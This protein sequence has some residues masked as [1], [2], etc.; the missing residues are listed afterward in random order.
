MS[1]KEVSEAEIQRIEREMSK[2]GMSSHA[3]T[4]KDALVV[5]LWVGKYRHGDPGVPA[6]L[7]ALDAL[8][9]ENQR[10]EKALR[11]ITGRDVP[12]YEAHMRP[13]EVAREA[14]AGDAE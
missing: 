11:Y 3:D 14:L 10:Y 1:G 5:R 2:R 12:G 9:A 8:L 4:I 7:A 6:A 13:E